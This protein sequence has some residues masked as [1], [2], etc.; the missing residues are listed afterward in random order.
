MVISG[1]VITTVTGESILIHLHREVIETSLKLSFSKFNQHAK[2]YKLSGT[3]A[4]L[5][6]LASLF[7]WENRDKR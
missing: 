4:E 5:R 1:H 6:E 2:Y 3:A 7:K